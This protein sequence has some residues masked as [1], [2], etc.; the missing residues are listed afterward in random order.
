[1]SVCRECTD[2]RDMALPYVQA[3]LLEV[4]MQRGRDEMIDRETNAQLEEILERLAQVLA[5]M[6]TLR[7]DVHTILEHM[8]IQM[9][10]SD[11]EEEVQ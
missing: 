3:A 4:P 5:E 8:P 11:P 2:D 10:P 9:I 7:Q 6:E 1:M